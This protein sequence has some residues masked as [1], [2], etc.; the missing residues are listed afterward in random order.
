VVAQAIAAAHLPAAVEVAVSGAEGVVVDADPDQLAR[1][2]TNLLV[3]ASQAMEGRGTARVDVRRE[4]DRVVARVAD[5]GPGVPADLRARIFEALFT[6]KA[7]GTGLGL[8][9]CRRIVEAHGGALTLEASPAGA[10]FQLVIPDAA[11]APPT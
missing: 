11:S 5:E 10:L 9:L 1:V 7:K 4:G 3:N 6:T 2:L 8:A